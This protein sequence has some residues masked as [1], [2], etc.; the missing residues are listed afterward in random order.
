ED[1]Q[2]KGVYNAVAPEHKTNKDF[3]ETLAQV[4]RKPLWFPNIPAIVMKIIFGKMSIMLLKGSRVSSEKITNA[5]YKFK[6]PNLKET[7]VNLLVEN[8][9]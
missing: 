6:F 1:A 8:T 4:L 2:M 5:G 9:K 7:F 3:T